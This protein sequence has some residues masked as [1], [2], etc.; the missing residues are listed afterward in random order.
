V[1]CTPATSCRGHPADFF[2]PDG[3]PEIAFESHEF[4]IEAALKML[5]ES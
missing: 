2:A 1:L 3:L 4:F 5:A